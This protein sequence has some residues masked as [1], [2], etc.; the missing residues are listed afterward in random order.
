[1][2][3]SIEQ[4]SFSVS[5]YGAELTAHSHQTVYWL[6]RQGYLN[7]E[8]T[9]DLLKRMV[10]VPIKN[11]K[12]FGQRLLERFFGKDSSDNAYVFP[13]TLLEDHETQLEVDNNDKPTLKVVK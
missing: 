10:V 4:F 3:Y 2:S 6:H 1:M 7:D 8:Q 11:E 13:I 5:E 9:L 12:K